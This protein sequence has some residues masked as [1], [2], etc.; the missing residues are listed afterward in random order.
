MKTKTIVAYAQE[1]VDT[2]L[3]LMPSIY[4]RDSLQALLGLFLEA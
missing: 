3:K 2:L 1:L 4:Q